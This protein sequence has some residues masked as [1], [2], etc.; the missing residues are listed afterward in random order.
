M[1][2]MSPLSSDLAAPLLA[3]AL[4]EGR[5]TTG[6]L[7]TIKELLAG[8]QCFEV[9]DETGRSVGSYAVEVFTHD[10]GNEAVVVAAVGAMPG[11][12]LTASVLP[13]VEQQARGAGCAAVTIHT[14]RRGLLAK[15]KAAGYRC[16]GF[17]MR[18]TINGR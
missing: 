9:I 4:G 12:D 18:K 14:R 3:P 5:D 10:G 1:L 13:G 16:D 11:V 2:S 8:A 17:I 6:G 7:M 15:L